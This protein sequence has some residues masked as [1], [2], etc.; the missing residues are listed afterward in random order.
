MTRQNRASNFSFLFLALVMLVCFSWLWRMD[1]STPR[2]DYS[3]VRQQLW[4][5]K[6]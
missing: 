4:Q 1:N 6:V 3:Q 5:D 2:L